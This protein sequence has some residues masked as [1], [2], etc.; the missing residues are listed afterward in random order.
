MIRLDKED[1][2]DHNARGLLPRIPREL[3]QFNWGFTNTAASMVLV[4]KSCDYL[5]LIDVL[6]KIDHRYS[7]VSGTIY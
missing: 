6:H 1:H 2:A 3:Y 7:I 5:R 4:P